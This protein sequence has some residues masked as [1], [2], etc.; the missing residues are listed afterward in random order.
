MWSVIF[1]IYA[2]SEHPHREKLVERLRAPL[3]KDFAAVA[4]LDLVN[5][6]ARE[7]KETAHP[8]DTKAGHALLRGWLA[9]TEE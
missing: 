3:P 7:Q 8:F 6:L 9:S 1:S 4:F 2:D 5:V